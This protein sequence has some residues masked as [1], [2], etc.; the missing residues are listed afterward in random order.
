MSK[1][2]QLTKFRSIVS[3]DMSAASITSSVSSIE[4]VDDI[5]IQ[6]NWTGS[7]VG[8]FSVQ[9]SIDYTQDTS[10]SPNVQVAGNWVDLVLTYWNGAAWVTGT[11]IPATVGSPIY[12]DL[13]LLSAPWI[14]CKYTKTSGTGTLSAFLTTKSVS[15]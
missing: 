10:S 13:P 14:R 15:G 11:S 1:K 7:P 3:G 6:F 9:I 2:S 8:V 5:G 12:I 4:F